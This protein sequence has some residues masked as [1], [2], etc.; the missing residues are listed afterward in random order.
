LA[1][2][3]GAEGSGGVYSNRIQ[4]TATLACMTSAASN[5][6]SLTS[7]AQSRLP[8]RSSVYSCHWPS[9]IAGH[10]AINRLWSMTRFCPMIGVAAVPHFR[11]IRGFFVPPSPNRLFG[12]IFM[13]MR[14]LPYFA[15]AKYG[16]FRICMKISPNR[17]FGLGGTKN[18]LMRLKWGTAATPIIG[19]NLVIDHKR[20]IA[21]CPAICDG[22]WHEYTLDLRGNR[23]WAGDVNE[24]W[25][26]A[27]DVMHAR[28][29]VDWMRFE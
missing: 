18:P 27:A 13:Q 6:S 16:K 23:D 7:P 9:Q 20:L 3:F 5:Q 22:Q 15:A 17:R 21:T 19:Q 11:R 24:L 8:R 14:N 2:T 28:V 25:F 10:V 29:A 12:E 26:E 4:S 1:M